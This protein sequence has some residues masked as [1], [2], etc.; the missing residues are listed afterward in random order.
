MILAY[1]GPE[2][3]LPLT[4]SLAAFAGVALMVARAAYRLLGRGLR[5]PG[6]R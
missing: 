6:R 5:L 1:F 4:S 3:Y 2:A